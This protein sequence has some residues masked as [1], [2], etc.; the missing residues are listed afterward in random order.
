LT[1]KQFGKEAAVLR[2]EDRFLNDLGAD[3]LDVAELSMIVEDELGVLLP[4]EL[5]DNPDLTLGEVEQAVCA[6]HQSGG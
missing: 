3:S 4:N 1:A 6:K 2:A 5:M